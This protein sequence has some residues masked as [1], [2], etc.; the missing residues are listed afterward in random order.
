[1]NASL[2]NKTA[3]VCGSTQGIG[4]A[5]AIKLAGMG[6]NVILVARNEKK[7]QE[8]KQKLATTDGQIHGFLVADF[9]KPTELK[10]IISDYINA[11]NKINIL[12]NNTGGPKEDQLLKLQRMNF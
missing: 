9:T 4:M 3:L 11:G 12:I 2:L 6:A 8:V 7:L 10:T 1:M 5:T